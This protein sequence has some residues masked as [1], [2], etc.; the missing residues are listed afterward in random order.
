[1]WE[2]TEERRVA[3]KFPGKILEKTQLLVNILGKTHRIGKYHGKIM[4]LGKKTEDLNKK[5]KISTPEL[6]ISS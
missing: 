2:K 1:M 6:K 3:G 4:V 5:M